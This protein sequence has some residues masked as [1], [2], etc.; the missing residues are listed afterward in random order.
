ML[1]GGM[2]DTCTV[3][4][5]GPLVGLKEM[6]F[7]ALAACARGEATQPMERASTIVA[8]AK[9]NAKPTLRRD[10]GKWRFSYSLA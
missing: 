3:V 6:V 4:P 5:T 8:A 1:A 7:A 2:T 9:A 10:G